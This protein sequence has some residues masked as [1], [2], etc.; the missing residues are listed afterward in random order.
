MQ[1]LVGH[2]VEPAAGFQFQ[3]LQSVEQVVFDV[4]DVALDPALVMGLAQRTGHGLEAEVRGQFQIAWME[5]GRSA[6]R[7]AQHGRAQIVDHEAARHTAEELEGTH[8]AAE[9]MLHLLGQ[10]EGHVQ[11]ATEAQG[12]H[13]EAQASSG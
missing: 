11:Q 10:R 7:M 8:M 13:E 12:Q 9:P 2:F 1:P 5:L 6:G 4:A 3:G